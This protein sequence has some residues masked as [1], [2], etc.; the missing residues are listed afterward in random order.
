MKTLLL[1]KKTRDDLEQGKIVSIDK[2]TG[3]VGVFVR[4]GL[5]SA[6]SYLY[7]ISE[8]RI[9]MTVLL[10]RV[11]GTYVIMNRMVNVPRAGRSYSLA[12]PYVP[13]PR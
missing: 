5:A 7:D 12:R 13:L 6:A 2:L 1:Q 10:G 8:L 3:R 9:G 4:N 11:D